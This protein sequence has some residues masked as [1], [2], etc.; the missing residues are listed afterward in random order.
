MS[1]NSNFL[2][3]LK[4][5]I[6]KNQKT[7]VFLVCLVM[8]TLFWLV[9]SLSRNFETTMTRPL[10]YHHLPFS[11]DLD[12]GLPNEVTFYFK[13]S[14]FSLF[15][16]HFREQPDSII[17]DL[18]THQKGHK[19]ITSALSNQLVTDLK[20]LRAEPEFILPGLTYKNRKSVPVRAVSDLK[21]RS[22]FSGTGSIILKP[23]SIIITGPEG[24]L[25]RISELETEPIRLTDI[26]RSMFGSIYLNKNFP[27]SITLSEPFVYY[28]L[29]V[30]EFTEG[31]FTI[32]V[33]LPPSQKGRINLIPPEVQV[34]FTVELKH[35]PKIKPSDFRV[36]ASVPLDQMPSSINAEIARQPKGISNVRMEPLTLNYLVKE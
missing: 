26:H 30:E 20:P 27:S 3:R 1:L 18:N 22:R 21:F 23:D 10:A 36:T 24:D 4:E 19:I 15:H 7:V 33:D 17:V 12:K 35:Y 31:V 16:L 29:S 6:R 5:W 11:T 14:G 32:P 8:A 28:Y 13:G 34:R 2:Q 25:D 9:N